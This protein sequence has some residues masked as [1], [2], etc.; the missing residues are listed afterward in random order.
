M[1][2][3][4]K[5]SG[6]LSGAYAQAAGEQCEE[7]AREGRLTAKNLVEIN[8]P[9]D[10]PLHKAFE[11][12]DGVAAENWREHQARHIIGS[13]ELVREE[14]QPVRA[15][16]NIV[17]SEP[18]YKHIETILQREDDTE[19]LLRTALGELSAFQR[20]YHQLKALANVFAAIDQLRIDEAS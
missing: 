3:R 8:R 10:A 12:R 13:L 1:V 9:E 18:E 7:L 11:W 17:R 20:K 6:Y 16:F 15:F 4:F 14:A 19:R 2:Y 5:S